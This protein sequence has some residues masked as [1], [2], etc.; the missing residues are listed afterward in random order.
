MKLQKRRAVSTTVRIPKGF[1]SHLNQEIFRL[2]IHPELYARSE[3][4]VKWK[5]DSV[6]RIPPSEVIIHALRTYTDLSVSASV[7]AV[8]ID[9]LENPFFNDA[10]QR[11]I[12]LTPVEKIRL[13][14]KRNRTARYLKSLPWAPRTHESRKR[15]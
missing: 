13:T 9:L 5:R 6:G 10:S 14:Q 1:Q 2:T 11:F 7:E 8:L 4:F 12:D 3:K 15:I